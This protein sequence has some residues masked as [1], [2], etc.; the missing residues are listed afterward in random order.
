VR[1]GFV[2]ILFIYTNIDTSEAPHFANG[3]ASLSAILKQ[4]GHQTTLLFLDTFPTR[5]ELQN[6]IETISPNLIGLSTGSN[7]WHYVQRLAKSIKSFSSLPIICGGPHPTLAPNE[8]MAEPGIDM[9]CMGEGEGA[10]LDVVHA[11]ETESSFSDIP[12]LWIN[13]NGKIIRNSPRPLIDDLDT[14]PFPDR[15]IFDYPYLLK[16]YPLTATLLMS[17]RGCPYHCP[18]CINHALAK[19]YLG[20]GK[21]T[22]L[23]SPQRVCDEIEYLHQTWGLDDVLIYDDTFTYDRKWTLEFAEE[24]KSRFDFPFAVNIRPETVDDELLITLKNAG[25]H[26]II[27][28]V[29]VGNEQ[30]RYEVLKRPISNEL[31]LWLFRKAHELNIRT[32][33]NTMMGI[34]GETPENLQETIDFIRKLAPDHAQVMVFYPYPGTDL[35]DFCQKKGY[36][37]SRQVVTTFVGDSVLKLPTVS[38]KQIKDAVQC[39]NWEA[40]RGR[41]ER[42][43]KGDIDLCLWYLD[44]MDLKT[45]RPLQA[46]E[47]NEDERIGIPAQ[48]PSELRVKYPAALGDSLHFAIALDPQVWDM[49]PE[50]TRFLIELR[51]GKQ[52]QRLFDRTIDPRHEENDRRWIDESIQLDQTG[53]CEI[54]LRTE[55]VGA[56]PDYGWAYWGHPYIERTSR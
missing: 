55:T 9:L 45:H 17:G 12:N 3:I 47:I 33:A 7:Q 53:E 25:L 46:I 39:F 26:R 14:L 2:K 11:M 13:Q 29:E 18:Y 5:E 10:I 54:R 30:I 51:Q 50:P 40:L 19:I 49:R 44:K 32:W 38:R 27:V 8:V 6:K 16:R 56:N 36:I 23:R 20:K 35:G 48:P 22:R 41:V 34:P 4:Y 1:P 31:L 28:G 37:T 15:N 52:I 42:Q 43:T 21:Y 24:Y